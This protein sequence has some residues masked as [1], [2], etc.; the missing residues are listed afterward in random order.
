M[1]RVTTHTVAHYLL[2]V[3]WFDI[4][5][6]IAV[7]YDPWPV[8]WLTVHDLVAY[9]EVMAEEYLGNPPFCPAVDMTG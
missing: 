6:M 4:V 8:G 3:G 9:F 7:N 5:A 2:P 1:F